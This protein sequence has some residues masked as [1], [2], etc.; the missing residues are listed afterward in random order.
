MLEPQH[1]YLI[2]TCE[3]HIAL[4]QYDDVEKLNEI[5]DDI[6]SENPEI[7]EVDLAVLAESYTGGSIFDEDFIRR[8]KENDF[9]FDDISDISWQMNS[10]ETA[11]CYLVSEY[12]IPFDN[13]ITEE[14]LEA[15]SDDLVDYINW[16]DVWR[17]YAIMGFRI[18]ETTD[19]QNGLFIVR[20]K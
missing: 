7:T 3:P 18:V 10:E 13:G 9:M 6:N 20:W 16:E 14:L 11:A 5:L 12:R 17:Q 2:V 15:M 19:P 4:G 8:V 1:E